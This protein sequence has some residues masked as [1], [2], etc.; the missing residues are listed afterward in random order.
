MSTER[1]ADVRAIVEVRRDGTLYFAPRGDCGACDGSCGLTL[2]RGGIDV[3]LPTALLPGQWV[4]LRVSTGRLRGAALVA[5]GLPL[6]GFLTGT[7]IATGAG[8]TD[9]DVIMGALCGLI[10]AVAV[11]ALT[12]AALRWKVGGQRVAVAVL[13]S[14]SGF[15]NNG[16]LCGATHRISPIGGLS[17]PKS[18]FE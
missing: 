8:L 7:A 12:A 9:G 5:F 18:N 3:P 16:A 1:A 17:N 15:V 6:A 10:L 11:A 2:G 4:R 14:A 13:D